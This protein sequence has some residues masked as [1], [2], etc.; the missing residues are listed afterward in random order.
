[1]SGTPA[2]SSIEIRPLD[3]HCY[4]R[5]RCVIGGELSQS[6]EQ[7]AEESDINLD[8]A[9]GD[10]IEQLSGQKRFQMQWR[11]TTGQHV[12]SNRRTILASCG[13]EFQ[14]GSQWRHGLIYLM[15]KSAIRRVNVHSVRCPSRVST[16]KRRP[17]SVVAPIEIDVPTRGVFGPIGLP[18]QTADD[19]GARS[20]SYFET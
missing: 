2:K 1:M 20:D 18:Q 19:E 5:C 7:I 17:Q 12:A 11:N 13:D 15:S 3:G 16:P 8:A 14:C 6:A 10:A 4:A 9:G